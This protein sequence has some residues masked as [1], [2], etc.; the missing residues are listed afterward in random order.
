VK[1]F[2]PIPRAGIAEVCINMKTDFTNNVVY[3]PRAY[4]RVA[5]QQGRPALDADFQETASNTD[6]AEVKQS[7][8]EAGPVA[9][10]ERVLLAQLQKADLSKRHAA[11]NGLAVNYGAGSVQVESKGVIEPNLIDSR[12][13][14]RRQREKLGN[15]LARLQGESAVPNREKILKEIVLEFAALSK[16]LDKNVSLLKKFKDGLEKM[17]SGSDALLEKTIADIATELKDNQEQ[18]GAL[19]RVFSNDTALAFSKKYESEDVRP[20]HGG[21]ARGGCMNAV[22]EGLEVLFGLG[23]DFR[24]E[25][26]NKS[27]VIEKK[28]GWE[29]GAANSVDLI[30]ETLQKKGLAGEGMQFRQKKGKWEPSVEKAIL[31]KVPSNVPGW[32]FFGM[33]ASGGYHSVMLAVDNTDQPPKIYWMDQFSEG[34]SARSS[35]YVTDQPEVTNKLDEAISKVGNATTTVWPLLRKTS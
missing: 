22:Y 20:L 12:E 29:D 14:V 9:L 31:D 16:A 6:P 8:E 2:D 7:A 21:N 17:R 33:S 32:Y 15:L 35:S 13:D 34:C 4:S 10:G 30:M 23:D 11:A 28:H 18:L 5:L 27:R 19:R 26:Y 25:V 1:L 24:R 3:F